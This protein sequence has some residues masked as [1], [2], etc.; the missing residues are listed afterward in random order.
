M[1]EGMLLNAL[2]G[3]TTCSSLTCPA[4]P[5]KALDEYV[6]FLQVNT[7]KKMMFCIY[8]TGARDYIMFCGL[9]RIPLDPTP[10]ML[11]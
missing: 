9:H 6:Q 11:S 8:A 5:L 2:G 7:I 3:L 10:E 4:M 1:M